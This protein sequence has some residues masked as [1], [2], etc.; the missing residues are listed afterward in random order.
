LRSADSEISATTKPTK[1]T[2]ALMLGPERGDLRQRRSHRTGDAD[3]AD[4]VERMAREGH[5]QTQHEQPEQ[6][7]HRQRTARRQ[8]EGGCGSESDG[9]HGVLQMRLSE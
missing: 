3:K 1:P 4:E 5:A 7:H 9:A 6:G 8:A 2:R